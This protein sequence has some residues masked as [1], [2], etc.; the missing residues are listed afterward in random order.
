M[1]MGL[2]AKPA[3]SV[4]QPGVGRDF[5]GHTRHETG[6]AV[7]VGLSYRAHMRPALRV[8]NGKRQDGTIPT[9][10]PRAVPSSLLQLVW[11]ADHSNVN[12]I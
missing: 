2:A 1:K 5:G 10:K 7:H 6:Q 11:N 8:I 3:P 4:A 9:R 12:S